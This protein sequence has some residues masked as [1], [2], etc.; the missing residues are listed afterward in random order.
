MKRSLSLL[1]LLTVLPLSLSAQTQKRILLEE[2]TTAPCGF[3]PE[4]DI[5]AA[6]LVRDH[7]SIIWFAHHAGFGTDSMT[8]NESKTIAGAFTTF[9]PGAC[10]DRGDHPIPVYTMPPYIA[11]S[12]QKWD[13]VC[14]A[15]LNDPPVADV[16]LMH[17]FHPSARSFTCKVD[18]RFISAPQPGDIRLNLFIVE[19]S[20]VGFGK[21]YDQTNYFNTTPGHAF[22][23]KGDP[24]VGYTHHRVLRAVP[25][26]AWGL[27][28]VIPNTPSPG[29][30]YSK[31]ITSIPISGRWNEAALDVIAFVSYYDTDAKKRPVINANSKRLLDASTD[32]EITD[33]KSLPMLSVYP[34]PAAD[35][36]FI[37]SSVPIAKR[38]HILMTDFTGRV[39]RSATMDAQS[40]L[41]SV[42]VDDLRP[43]TYFYRAVENGITLQT[44]KLFVIR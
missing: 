8:V 7:P 34:M 33:I 4:G 20:V 13:S 15:H 42:A 32:V 11:V 19:D 27:T 17:T 35:R 6:K 37:R 24:I 12:R 18:V 25:T 38:V 44:G 40:T 39:V 9:A 3:C 14:T 29:T 1:L 5:I 31:T 22:Y 41:L 36:L 21:G 26:G 2:F 16:R 28:G 23:Q 30:T 10:I 43:G